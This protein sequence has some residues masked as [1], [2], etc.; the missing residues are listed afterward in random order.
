MRASLCQTHVSTAGSGAGKGTMTEITARQATP[1]TKLVIP[2]VNEHGVGWKI[3]TVREWRG[4][5]NGY[6]ALFSTDGHHLG[7]Y[8]ADHMF[9][10]AH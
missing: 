8:E 4:L 1:G 9:T 3:A 7:Q 10:V 5:G 6:A 2:V